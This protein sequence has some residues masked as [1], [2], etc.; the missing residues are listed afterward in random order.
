M[1]RRVAFG[2]LGFAA[3]SVV[4]FSVW[5]FGG[6]ALSGW[7]GEGGM[8]A[9]VAVVFV[10]A[11]G[12][13]LSRLVEG[14]RPLFRFYRTFVPAFVA[15]AAAWCVA[16]FALRH[17]QREW[18]GSLAGSL[19]FAAVAGLA[20]GSL[21]PWARVAAVLFVAHSAGY[22][23]GGQLYYRIKPEVPLLAMLGW[24]L[25]YGLGFGAGIGY[26][27]HAFQPPKK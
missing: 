11:A 16:W 5:A 23:L 6:R 15:Y 4:A 20:L 24:G 25:V 26:A 12:P 1:I 21:R 14:P 22:F 8:F 7:A 19:A 10:V 9:A 2:S 27:Y 13:V 17:A 18:L 3:V